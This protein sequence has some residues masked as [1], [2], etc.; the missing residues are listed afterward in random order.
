[1]ASYMNLMQLE[2][3]A[4]Y[5][6]WINKIAVNKCKHA[7]LKKG[8]PT[9]DYDEVVPI[10]QEENEN[11]LPEDYIIN[12]EKRK[13][14][15]DIM[16]KV[17][18]PIKYQTVLLYYFNGLKIQEIGEIMECPEGTVKYR[19]S[20]AKSKVKA[21][22]IDYEVANN[23]KLYTHGTI[24]F[25]ASLLAAASMDLTVPNIFESIV[26]GVTAL[27]ASGATVST[28]LVEGAAMQQA[29]MGS[30]AT[31]QVTMGSVATQQ[32]VMG[33]AAAQQTAMGGAAVQQTAMGSAAVQQ[34]AM[35]TAAV[36]KAGAIALKTKII[37]GAVVGALA[38]SGVTVGVITHKKNKE[39]KQEVTTE[40]FVTEEPWVELPD[41]PRPE[42]DYD[43][44][45]EEVTEE[46]TEEV[47]E[48]PTEGHYANYIEVVSNMAAFIEVNASRLPN[49]YITLDYMCFDYDLDGEIEVILYLGYYDGDVYM[50]D[51]GFLDYSEE[52]QEVYIR[53]VNKGDV[54]DTMFYMEYNGMMAR[55]SWRTSPMES[56]IYNVM[57]DDENTLIYVLEDG[58]DYIVSDITEAGMHPLPVYGDWELAPEILD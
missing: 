44:P 26:T 14:V 10:V 23:E 28:G 29:T 20:V 48:V 3:D 39:K 7:L 4:K 9:I 58:Y 8:A 45:T 46:T 38:V 12:K 54:D 43:E 22:V 2:D 27:F 15:M 56:Y 1:M 53:A 30:V 51:I 18:S 24:P 21:G 37:I 17:L 6:A 19:L 33:G 42:E 49:D 11:F 31:Q 41:T 47:A 40:Q 13:Q 16:R 32:T 55:Y 36:A 57:V 34:T 50:R 5:G 52:N 35:S 25:L